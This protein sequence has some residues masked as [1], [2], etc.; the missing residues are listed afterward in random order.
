MYK[1][2]LRT[3]EGVGIFPLIS[4]LLFILFFFLVIWGT[5]R[6]KKEV[7]DNMAAIPFD[8]SDSDLKKYKTTDHV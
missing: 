1:D 3:I 8:G 4:L 5:M 6:A 2:V 7:I